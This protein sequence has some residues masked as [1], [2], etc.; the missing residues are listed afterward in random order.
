MLLEST[1]FPNGPLL[2]QNS[3]INSLK[4]VAEF[5]D[6]NSPTGTGMLVFWPQSLNTSS[7]KWFAN[8][9]HIVHTLDVLGDALEAVRSIL[10]R[11]HMNK[12]WV[13]YFKPVQDL[14]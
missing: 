5:N 9:N 8:A 4:A 6:K 3:M 2:D 11:T 10:V 14:M 7:G 12:I 13:K 1:R